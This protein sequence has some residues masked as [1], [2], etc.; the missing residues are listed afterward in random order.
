MC[1]FPSLLSPVPFLFYFFI[2]TR[3]R[4]L[5]SDHKTL[6]RR[7]FFPCR[8]SVFFDGLIGA[9]LSKQMLFQ[10]HQSN[11]VSIDVLFLSKLNQT[12]VTEA[13]NVTFERLDPEALDVILPK[14]VINLL[15]RIEKRRRELLFSVIRKLCKM[16]I[17]TYFLSLK[18]SPSRSIFTFQ[19][20]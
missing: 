1:L 18:S 8:S 16:F 2:L 7:A 5:E 19:R 12:Q 9:Q 10:D 3:Q 14:K 4:K 15:T 11:I 20:E 13:G 17:E 6:E